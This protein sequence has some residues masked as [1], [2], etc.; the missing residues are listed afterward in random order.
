MLGTEE[1]W[2]AWPLPKRIS[3]SYHQAFHCCIHAC[4][5][6]KLSC[7][8]KAASFMEIQFKVQTFLL[9]TEW[10]GNNLIENRAQNNETSG[11]SFQLTFSPTFW[12]HCQLLSSWSNVSTESLIL[13]QTFENVTSIGFDQC[14]IIKNALQFLLK[15]GYTRLG[16]IIGL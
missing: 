8:F 6:L 2:K 15:L 1:F 16:C 5:Y 7:N 11:Q 9:S 13:I 10:H 3:A 12:C 4:L 14:L